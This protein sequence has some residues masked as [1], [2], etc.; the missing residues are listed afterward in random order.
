MKKNEEDGWI[1]KTI[2]IGYNVFLGLQKK[3]VQNI[4]KCQKR[5]K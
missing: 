4:R 1:Y 5:R 2:Q 3:K